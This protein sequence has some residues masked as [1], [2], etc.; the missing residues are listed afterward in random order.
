MEPQTLE[1]E[2]AVVGCW[3][4]N[5]RTPCTFSIA[6]GRQRL[7]ANSQKKPTFAGLLNPALTI[8]QTVSPV[9]FQVVVPCYNP[10]EGWE[11]ALA[12]NFAA[13][14]LAI[15]DL[16]GAIG[17]IVV[18]DGSATSITET[19]I[20]RLRTLVPSVEVVSYQKNRGK[21][22]ALRQGVQAADADFVL[23]TDIDFP[24]T[25]ESMQRVAETLLAEGGIAAGNRD[26][27]YYA[28]VP[29]FR[30][31]L[32]KGLRWLLRYVLRQ[33]IDDSQCGLKGF[34]RTGKA[35]FLETTI[36]RFLFDLEFLMLANGRVPVRP[37]PVE[38]RPGVV[39]SSVGWKIL[40]AEGGNFLRLF[41]RRFFQ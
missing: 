8:L 34:D 7:T 16:S 22:Y 20:Q 40:L 41:F 25:V 15:S 27:A 10:S 2:A 24:Y 33:P 32:S 13:F 29:V 18:N 35:I 11:Q 23:V 21:G 6:L 12:D 19:T 17:L 26:T 39:F 38:L 3:L 31:W 9:R 36:D 4:P 37:V 1:D 5:A 28:H 30:R 14:T